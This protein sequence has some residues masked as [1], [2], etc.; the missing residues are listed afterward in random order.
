MEMESGLELDWFFEDRV[1][2][3]RTIDYSI[4]NI[5]EK[6]GKTFVSLERIGELPMPIEVVA[7]YKDGSKEKFYMPLRVMR[8]QKHDDGLMPRKL[9]SDWAWTNPRY[10][11]SIDHPT[12][13]I[14]SIEIDPS[15]RMADIEQS[16]NKVIIADV[17]ADAFE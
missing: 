16:N 2:T 3:T 8:G 7:E 17:T 1:G 10:T 15:K 5:I 14:V 13:D 11:F 12:S 9:L 4:R 6:D